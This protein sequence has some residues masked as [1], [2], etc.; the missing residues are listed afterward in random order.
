MAMTMT[1]TTITTAATHARVEIL[2]TN[3]N[4]EKTTRT[5]A[6]KKE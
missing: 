2:A 6:R 4:E 3:G 5:T 1:I